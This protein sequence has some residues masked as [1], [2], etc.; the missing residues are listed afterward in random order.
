MVHINYAHTHTHLYD[1][2]LCPKGSNLLIKGLLIAVPVL[3]TSSTLQGCISV[4]LLVGL[5]LQIGPQLKHTFHKNESN[6]SVSILK[7]IPCSHHT[8]SAGRL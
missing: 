4:D 6:Y 7:A 1:I 3:T 2:K 5:V 8:H